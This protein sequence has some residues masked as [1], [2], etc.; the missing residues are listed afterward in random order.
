[1]PRVK[2]QADIDAPPD[3]VWHLLM[4]PARYSEIAEPTD[5]MLDVGDGIVKAGYVYRER[6]GIPPFKSESTWTVTTFEPKSH[7]IHEGDDGQMKLNL[8]I[9]IEAAGS[10][11]RLTQE[12][13]LTPRWFIAPLSAVMWPLMLRKR[14]QEAMDKTVVNVKRIVEAESS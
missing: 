3:A 14:A 12:L 9:R 11:S 10:G 2:A 4:Q 8:D 6:G 13:E 5:E 1:M 7:Q